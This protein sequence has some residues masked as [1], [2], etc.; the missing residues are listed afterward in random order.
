MLHCR[1]MAAVQQHVFLRQSVF[2]FE[3]LVCLCVLYAM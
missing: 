1:S 2:F 3:L